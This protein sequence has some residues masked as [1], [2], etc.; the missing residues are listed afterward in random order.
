MLTAE[1]VRM[2]TD[3]G[4]DADCECGADADRK[5]QILLTCGCGLESMNLFFSLLNQLQPVFLSEDLLA[6]FLLSHSMNPIS[7]S[8]DSRIPFSLLTNIAGVKFCPLINQEERDNTNTKTGNGI[9]LL[10]RFRFKQ[11][12]KSIA[13][14]LKFLSIT[15]QFLS[16]ICTNSALFY[17]QCDRFSHILN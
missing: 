5:R 14:N 4:I 11:Q 12:P 13:I 10:T 8:C 1:A 3:C 6:V 2:R 7:T 17:S 9:V 15:A 16:I